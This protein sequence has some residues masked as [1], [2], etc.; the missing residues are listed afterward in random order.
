MTPESIQPFPKVEACKK[1]LVKRCHKGKSRVLTDTPEKTEIEKMKAEELE[2]KTRPKRK[3][4]L[5]F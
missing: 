1:I 4:K 2:K 3:V 5:I